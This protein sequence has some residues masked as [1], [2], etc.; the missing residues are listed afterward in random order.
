MMQGSKADSNVCLHTLLSAGLT[1]QTLT[2]IFEVFAG[3]RK[4]QSNLAICGISWRQNTFGH[5]HHNI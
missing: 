2:M 1:N 3:L 4:L 5:Q